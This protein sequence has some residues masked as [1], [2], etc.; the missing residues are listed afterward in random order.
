MSETISFA[1][2][3][4]V[5]NGPSLGSAVDIDVAG[6]EKLTVSLAAGSSSKAVPLLPAGVVPNLFSVS[7]TPVDALITYDIGGGPLALDG[8]LVLVGKGAVGTLGTPFPSFTFK[9]GTTT[10]AVIE[11]FVGRSS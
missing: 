4:R 10:D 3:I 2:T 5:P 1:Y 8:P 6:Y 7:S 9:N 11:V